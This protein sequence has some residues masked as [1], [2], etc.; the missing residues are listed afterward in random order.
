MKSWNTKDARKVF[1]WANAQRSGDSDPEQRQASLERLAIEIGR[2]PKAIKNFIRRELPPGQRPWS[3]KPRWEVANIDASEAGRSAE[4]I[5]KFHERHSDGSAA[6]LSISQVARD[7][8]VSRTFVY[9]LLESGL[10]RRFKG[11]IA[12]S[13]FHALLREHPEAIPYRRLNRGQREWLVLNGYPDS[14][15]QVKPPS[16]RGLL[17]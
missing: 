9:R 2:T 12:E 5:R 7:L 4:A 16:V 6:V 11:G 17:K 13:S 14:T 15:L 3:E 10:L 1:D 8:G